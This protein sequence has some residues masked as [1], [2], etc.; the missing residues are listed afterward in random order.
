MDLK[1]YLQQLHEEEKP[2]SKGQGEIDVL[3]DKI[4]TGE[5]LFDEEKEK[6][7]VMID[8]SKK[9]A[10]KKASDR[11]D[12]IMSKVAKDKYLSSQEE[13]L[14]AISIVAAKK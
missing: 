8:T 13:D 9:E 14:L 10:D 5:R 3:M 2:E 1:T 11:L 12:K 7:S 6:L 4:R